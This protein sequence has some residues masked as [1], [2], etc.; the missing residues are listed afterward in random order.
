[1]PGPRRRPIILKPTAV[2]ALV[3]AALAALPAGCSF[4][5]VEKAPPREEW[6]ESKLSLMPMKGCTESRT[7]EIIDIGAAVGIVSIL[8]A[9]WIFQQFDPPAQSPEGDLDPGFLFVVGEVLMA[10]ASLP[11]AISA[12]WGDNQIDRCRRYKAGPPYDD[13]DWPR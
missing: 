3:L 12:L 6:P 1:M 8:P 5:L 9:L 11:F 7:P 13:Y 4:V 10:L 2:V